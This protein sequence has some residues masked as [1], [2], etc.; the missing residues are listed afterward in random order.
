MSSISRRSLVTTA[1]ALPIIAAVTVPALAEAD[2][3][4]VLRV[5]AAPNNI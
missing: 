2:D 4:E 5:A 1:A 3:A